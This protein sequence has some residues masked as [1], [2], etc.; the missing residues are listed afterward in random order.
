MWGY[1]SLSLEIL[2]YTRRP[3]IYGE[4][5]L[6]INVSIL[7]LLWSMVSSFIVYLT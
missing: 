7:S 1:I 4:Y 2:V 6:G 5:L 3:K